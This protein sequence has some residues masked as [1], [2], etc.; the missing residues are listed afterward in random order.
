MGG[1][2]YRHKLTHTHTHARTVTPIPLTPELRVVHLLVHDNGLQ[3]GSFSND[4]LD[5]PMDELQ[6]LLIL[7][8]HH[9]HCGHV[10]HLDHRVGGEGRGGEG[11]E[12][13]EEEEEEEGEGRGRG[14][15]GEERACSDEEQQKMR[16]HTHICKQL[17][18]LQTKRCGTAFVLSM[19][20]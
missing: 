18:C 19:C 8:D 3:H 10:Q 20:L 9:T 5:H 14:G 11:E 1:G 7:R 2:K 16:T 4:K 12:E 17:S 6:D 15:G 13:G